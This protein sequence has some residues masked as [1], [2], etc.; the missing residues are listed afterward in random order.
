MHVVL[1][2]FCCLM[3]NY[4]E[5]VSANSIDYPML[6]VVEVNVRFHLLLLLMMNVDGNFH[7]DLVLIAKQLEANPYDL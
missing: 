1:Y 7:Y 4:F 2:L 6:Q 3:M 5:K